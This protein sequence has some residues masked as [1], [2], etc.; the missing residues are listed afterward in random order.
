MDLKLF[1]RCKS[2]AWHNTRE[3]LGLM[4]GLRCLHCYWQCERERRT[5]TYDR[6]NTDC[7]TGV[8]VMAIHPYATP[9]PSTKDAINQP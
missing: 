5:L 8:F 2:M 9:I 3:E 4:G 6:L 7:T 1:I